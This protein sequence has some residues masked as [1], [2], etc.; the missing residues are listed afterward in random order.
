MCTNKAFFTKCTSRAAMYQS[1][2]TEGLPVEILLRDGIFVNFFKIYPLFYQFENRQE[3]L[4]E[5]FRIT[6]NF[7]VDLFHLILLG[8]KDAREQCGPNI[9]V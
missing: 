2:S 4:R 8:Y 7:K 1:E 5:K 9:A 3:K 6:H